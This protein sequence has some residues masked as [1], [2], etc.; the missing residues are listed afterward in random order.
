MAILFSGDFHANVQNELASI[1]RKTLLAQFGAGLYHTIRYHIILG[2][3]GFLWPKNQKADA[4]NYEILA[5]RPF[6][7]LC[8][9]GN[10]EPILGRTDIPEVDIGLGE[11]VYQINPLVSYLKRG[12]IYTIDGYRF[13]VLGGALSIDRA[14]RIPGISW[15]ANEF[16]SEQE[17][18]DIFTLLEKENTFDFV[19]SHTGPDRINTAVF[20]DIAGSSVKYGDEV[21]LLNDKID[22]KITCRQWWCGHWHMYRYHYDKIGNR[23]YQYLY[24]T[25]KILTG[26]DYTILPS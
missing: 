1:T 10:H 23:G 17:K 6:P 14:Y 9:I 11:T 24:R 16:W 12:K 22:T 20:S 26:N 19:L 2:D 13:L 3:G 4:Y 8:V 7:V 21:A 18:A 25:V 5:R 15:W